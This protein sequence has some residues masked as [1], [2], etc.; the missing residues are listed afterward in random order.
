LVKLSI[1]RMLRIKWSGLGWRT[2]L[3]DD[4]CLVR[5]EFS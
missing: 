4:I 1:N 5:S 3:S 2:S